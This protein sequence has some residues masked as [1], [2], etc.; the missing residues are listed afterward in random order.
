VGKWWRADYE[1]LRRKSELVQGLGGYKKK[2]LLVNKG[3]FKDK[4]KLISEGVE[5]WDLRI[6]EDI[7][8]KSR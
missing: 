7:M 5:L 1:E 3:G 8:K 4:E 6:I 2:Y